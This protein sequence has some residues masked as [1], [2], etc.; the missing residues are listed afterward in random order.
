MARNYEGANAVKSKENLT[1]SEVRVLLGF[2][3]LLL[4][5]PLYWRP[6]LL[7]N[8]SRHT[9]REQQSGPCY[10]TDFNANKVCVSARVTNTCMEYV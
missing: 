6:L 3:I 2:Q 7:T 5:P 10:Y 8:I 4:R 1:F 9:Q